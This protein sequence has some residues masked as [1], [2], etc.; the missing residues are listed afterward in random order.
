VGKPRDR[1]RDGRSPN[2]GSWKGLASIAEDTREYLSTWEN[3]R[4]PAEKYWQLDDERILVL[5]HLF[6]RGKTSRVD[7][8]EMGARGAVL[9]HVSG[10]L[11]TR[12]VTY[13]DRD[14]AFADL[15]LTLDT[16]T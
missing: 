1:I 15:G 11:V 10:G 8:G 16:G 13:F 3:Y 14:N 5:V 9:F 6:G 12:L 4:L 2:P 7:P